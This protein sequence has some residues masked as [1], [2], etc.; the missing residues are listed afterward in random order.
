MRDLLRART[1]FFANLNEKA[2][3]LFVEH[4]VDDLDTLRTQIEK[5][6]SSETKYGIEFLC[7]IL[8]CNLN[9]ISN[10]KK[11]KKNETYYDKKQVSC[12][13]NRH[14]AGRVGR[15]G[16]QRAFPTHPI[17]ARDRAVVRH[18]ATPLH[19]ARAQLEAAQLEQ[20]KQ[21]ATIR[22]WRVFS[23]NKKYSRTTYLTYVNSFHCV[24]W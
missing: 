3:N 6:R 14:P 4:V 7:L 24:N 2:S 15:A 19:C 11:T 8:I 22:E 20:L 5:E 18:L 10:K 16:S 23:N 17:S 9:R 13:A 1:S 21:L 12:A